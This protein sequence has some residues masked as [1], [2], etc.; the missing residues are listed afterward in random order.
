MSDG[1]IGRSIPRSRSNN[2]VILL[3]F[4]CLIASIT[5]FVR[6]VVA[7]GFSMKNHS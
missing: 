7:S 1:C 3:L 6:Y 5:S 2:T 4:C